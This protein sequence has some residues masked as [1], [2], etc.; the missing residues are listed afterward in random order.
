MKGIKTYRNREISLI[1]Q[2]LSIVAG[3]GSIALLQQIFGNS[4]EVLQIGMSH[5]EMDRKIYEK[6]RKVKQND[7]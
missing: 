6:K 1:T 5:F 4:E 7:K 3:F 2:A